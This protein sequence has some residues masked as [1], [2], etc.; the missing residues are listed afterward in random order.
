M[1]HWYTQCRTIHSHCNKEVTSAIP[2]V[3]YPTRLLDLGSDDISAIRLV[4]S[5]DEQP[6]SPYVTLSHCWG[7][8][9]VTKLT[10]QNMAVLKQ[11]VSLESLPKT[12][13]DAIKITRQLRVRYLWIDSLCIIQDSA[14]DWRREALTMTDV[15]SHAICNIAATWA[16]SPDDECFAPRDTSRLDPCY[17]DVIDREGVNF[18]C[19]LVDNYLWADSITEAPLN[20]RAWVVQE[21]VLPRRTLH[22]AKDQIFW[23]CREESACEMYHRGIPPSCLEGP[24][25]RLFRVKRVMEMSENSNMLSTMTDP[26]WL[27]RQHSLWRHIVESYS[28]T[29]LTKAS[30]KLVAIS[31]LAKKLQTRLKTD[32]IAGLW[33]TNIPYHL[34]WCCQGPRL[35]NP[36]KEY[37]A[38][39]WSWASIDSEVNY[40]LPTSDRA[41][42]KPLVS[43]VDIGVTNI[44]DSSFGQ[45]SDGFLRIQGYAWACRVERGS[46]DDDL[47]ILGDGFT[48]YYH[49]IME[50][51]IQIRKEDLICMPIMQDIGTGHMDPETT[52]TGLILNLVD[53]R[54]NTF[55][56]CGLVWG[57]PPLEELPP[58]GEQKISTVV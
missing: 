24:T 21:R 38:P 10:T 44:D 49:C 47:F 35:P 12:Y 51:K 58:S 50:E 30:D 15:Y 19:L 2:A 43:I 57:L 33:R 26:Q 17:V 36:R 52:V 13:Q 28:A 1:N 53:G 14:D 56:R 42:L 29:K 46:G 23:E 37:R 45:V 55:V 9:A 54:P 7:H 22:F 32:Y 31:G 6:V 20:S 48:L 40:Y 18:T 11:S 39:S 8:G 34:L 16:S 4:D 25:S 41:L 5:K 27:Q 3:H